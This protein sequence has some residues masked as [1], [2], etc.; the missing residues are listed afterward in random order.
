MAVLAVTSGSG[1]AA[2]RG[3]AGR[4]G[5][6]LPGAAP[7]V[8]DV[9]VTMQDNF[10]Q[11]SDLKVPQIQFIDSGWIFLLCV[12]RRV[13]TVTQTAPHD[14]F[15]AGLADDRGQW[16]CQGS[17]LARTELSSQLGDG[18]HGHSSVF[19]LVDVRRVIAALQTLHLPRGLVR[20]VAR[21]LCLLRA[22]ARIADA[23]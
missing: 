2:A 15:H 11:C 12:Q 4:G 23:A 5:R 22:R 8:V 9:S 18:E 6:R 14:R 1:W 16:H 13:P 21:E 17:F 10:Q 19:D 3:V 20:G 7:S